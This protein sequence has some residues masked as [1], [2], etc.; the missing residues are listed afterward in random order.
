M[1]VIKS[2][3]GAGKG[4]QEKGSNYVLFFSSFR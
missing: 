1:E 4:H 3:G 2:G